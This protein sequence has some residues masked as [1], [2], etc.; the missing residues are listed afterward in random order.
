VLALLWS[1]LPPVLWPIA[2][3]DRPMRLL[4]AAV[5]VVGPLL[6]LL[7]YRSGK[8]HLRLDLIVIA[9][10]QLAFLGY[11]VNMLGRSRPVYTVAAVDRL[12]L[13]LANDI[14]RSDLADAR[15]TERDLSWR[16]PRLVGLRLPAG[17][18]SGDFLFSGLTG[19]DY[20]LRPAFYVPFEQA[21]PDLLLRARSVELMMARSPR[22]RDAISH[23]L[24]KL[25]RRA[26]EVRFVPITSRRGAAT[27]LVDAGNGMPLQALGLDPWIAGD[28]E[29]S[30]GI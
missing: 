9:L 15:L 19:K 21:A 18:N 14:D 26:S 11:V 30:P 23:A 10:I 8:H 7:V 2:G 25:G 5:L 6:T 4:I 12:E 1:W 24:V 16:G 22:D 27:M 20:P 13:V 29:A 17:P 3:P 28:G